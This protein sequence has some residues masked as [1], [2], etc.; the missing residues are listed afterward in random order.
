MAG[1][2]AMTCFMCREKRAK[3][4]SAV[5]RGK[6]YVNA[7]NVVMFCSVRC[8]ANYGLLWGVPEVFNAFHWCQKVQEWVG[9]D[10]FDCDHCRRIAESGDRV[11]RN[12]LADLEEDDDGEEVSL[13]DDFG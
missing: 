2:K 12:A 9:H 13:E 7:R 3:A 4:L 6:V 5:V 11:K 8:A 10:S 1:R